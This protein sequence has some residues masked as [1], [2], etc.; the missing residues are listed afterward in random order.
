[1]AETPKFEEANLS[2]TESIKQIRDFVWSHKD[3]EAFPKMWTN[4]LSTCRELYVRDEI[5]RGELEELFLEYFE[6]PR[7]LYN[8]FGIAAPDVEGSAQQAIMEEYSTG[9][10][11]GKEKV[12]FEPFS[13][14]ADLMVEGGGKL[15]VKTDKLPLDKTERF[16]RVTAEWVDVSMALLVDLAKVDEELV[17][18][19]YALIMEWEEQNQKSVAKDGGIG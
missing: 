6:S 19:I 10:T 15:K 7:K 13:V 14:E 1:M 18:K 12:P 5:S 4:L 17:T 9:L 11:A 2:L 8:A 16:F 3:S